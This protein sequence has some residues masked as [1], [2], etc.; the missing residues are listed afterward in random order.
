ML[1][2]AVLNILIWVVVSENAGIW[3]ID[4]RHI[5]TDGEHV[6]AIR[7]ELHATVG[8]EMSGTPLYLQ[9][10]IIHSPGFK[11]GDLKSCMFD[12]TRR[13]EY[14][15]RISREINETLAFGSGWHSDLTFYKTTPHLSTVMGIELY[16]DT[17]ITHFKDMRHVLSD[18]KKV[19]GDGVLE[20][21]YA[22]HT[23][24]HNFWAIHPVIRT[25][26]PG[27][28]ALFV[29]RAFTRSIVGHENDDLLDR[30]LDFIDNHKDSEFEQEWGVGQMLIWDNTY[31]QHSAPPFDWDKN[32]LDHRREIRRVVTTGW[33]PI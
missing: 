14:F 9:N 33:V 7:G 2:F 10:K 3:L 11:G 21:L 30:L 24:K 25:D 28:P 12:T 8:A 20:G 29:N 4:A 5:N 6:R 18:W 15:T 27:S 31:L 17:T 1:V 16:N 22:N 23:D 19:E 26:V 32:P 13:T